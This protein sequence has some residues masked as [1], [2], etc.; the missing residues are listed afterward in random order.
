[1][2]M[3]SVAAKVNPRPPRYHEVIS[4]LPNLLTLIEVRIAK[5]FSFTVCKLKYTLSQNPPSKLV[6]SPD[7]SGEVDHHA[8]VNELHGAYSGENGRIHSPHDAKIVKLDEN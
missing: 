6:T 4:C 5:S 1:M 7:C 8:S 2:T 3:R